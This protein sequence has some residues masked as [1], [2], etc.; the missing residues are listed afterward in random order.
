MLVFI[1]ISDLQ[2][3]F[4]NGKENVYATVSINTLD[5][6]NGNIQRIIKSSNVL[7]DAGFIYSN[8]SFSPDGK[9][10][11]FQHSGSDVSGGFSVIDLDGKTV[12]NFPKDKTDATPYWRPQFTPDGKGILCYSPAITINE[13]DKIY[14]VD[15]ITGKKRFVTEGSNPTFV[16]GGS[17]IVFERKNSKGNQK[18]SKKIDIW[19]LELKDGSKPK[20]I[21]QHASTPSGRF[22]C[23]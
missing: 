3:S 13:Q 10:I 20:L 19:S 23:P 9:L 21:I 22:N 15:L 5:F 7:L 4:V 2:F 16:C 12:F 17:K 6:K 14:L 11:A 18:V 1:G 8:P